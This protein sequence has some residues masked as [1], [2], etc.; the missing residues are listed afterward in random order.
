MKAVA[1]LHNVSCDNQSRSVVNDCSFNVFSRSAS[2]QCSVLDVV[3]FPHSNC[4]EGAT[5][6][7]DGENSL[8]GRVEVCVNGFWGTLPAPETQYGSGYRSTELE[9]AERICRQFGFPWECEL[10]VYN[11]SLKCKTLS[12]ECMHVFNVIVAMADLVS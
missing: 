3:C 12:V 4:T 10:R 6:L 11:E 2:E 9:E 1:F 8:D 7:A 5:R